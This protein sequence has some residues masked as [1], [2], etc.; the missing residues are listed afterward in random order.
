MAP[1][2][3]D[4]LAAP[5]FLQCSRAKL[6]AT[7]LPLLLRRIQYLKLVTADFGAGLL[8]WVAFFLLRKHLLREAAGLELSA[9][10]LFIWPGTRF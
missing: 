7:Q 6:H 10:A 1:R 9:G 8:A 3:L 4:K 2:C 5:L